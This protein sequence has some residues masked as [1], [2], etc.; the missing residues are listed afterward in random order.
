MQ[1]RLSPWPRSFFMEQTSIYLDGERHGEEEK[2]LGNL[3]AGHEVGR[4]LVQPRH[5]SSRDTLYLRAL[6]IK[7]ASVHGKKMVS[8]FPVPSPTR[9]SLKS[10]I[11]A[12]DGKMANLFL[13]C[14]VCVHLLY[15]NVSLALILPAL[16]TFDKMS[17]CKLLKTVSPNDRFY[18]NKCPE[19]D[20][21]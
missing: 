10:D 20:L 13:Q 16:F 18:F 1:R 17:Y 15:S 19:Y 5:S 8:H 12:G 21:K 11:R 7:K 6:M 2:H 9:E 14:T 4:L 3:I